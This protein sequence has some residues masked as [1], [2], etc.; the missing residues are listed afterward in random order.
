MVFEAIECVF[1]ILLMQMQWIIELNIQEG[2]KVNLISQF[3]RISARDR[4]EINLILLNE[5]FQRNN[6]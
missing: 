1:S 3:M 4:N 5:Y 6:T 2:C